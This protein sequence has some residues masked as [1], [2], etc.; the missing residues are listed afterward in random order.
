M[1]ENNQTFEQALTRLEEV[2]RE[3]ESTQLPLN[4]ALDLFAEGIAL[5]KYCNNLLEQAEQKISVLMADGEI[6][7]ASIA[8][9][10]G[11]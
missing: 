9:S 5:S 1:E 11:N 7:D 8:L 3:L 10:G 6:R 2:V 4:Q